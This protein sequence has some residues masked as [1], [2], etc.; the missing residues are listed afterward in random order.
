MANQFIYLQNYI[1]YE[2]ILYIRL[3]EFP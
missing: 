3:D 1:R 2:I